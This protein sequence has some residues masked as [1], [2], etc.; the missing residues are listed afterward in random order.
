MKLIILPYSA[1]SNPLG[2]PGEYPAERKKI[3]DKDT[4]HD[5]WIEVT[6]EEW[7]RRYETHYSTV[8]ALTESEE[9]SKKTAEQA[10]QAEVDGYYVSL[11]SLRSKLDG[12]EK[13]SE[14]DLKSILGHLIDILIAKGNLNGKI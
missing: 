13:I 5:G 14:S 1:T 4:V 7:K 11:K 8:A 10:K 12:E 2:F 3:D 9:S 6:E